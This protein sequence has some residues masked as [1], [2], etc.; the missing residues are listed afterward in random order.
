MRH[1]RITSGVA[2]IALTL[3]AAAARATDIEVLHW[4]TSGGEARALAELTK[5]LE[6]SGHR[7]RDFSVAGGGGDNAMLLLKTRVVSGYPPMAA[8]IKGP[9]IREWAEEGLLADIGDVAKAGN[10]DATL[11]TVVANAMK[12]EGRYVAAP[13]NVHRVNW[14]WI[15]P[16]VLKKSGVEPPA[17]WDAL[18][19]SADSIRKAGFVPIAHGGQPWQD[20][21][22][23]ESVALGVGG[24]DFYRR[25][26][27]SLEAATIQSPTMIKALDTFKALRKL[28][29]AGANNREW[30]AA[31]AMVINGKAAVQFMGDWAKG[32]FA[33]AG[34]QP[35]R[36][37]LCLPAP[38]TDKTYTYNIDSFAF[39]R[40]RQDDARKAQADLANALMG[41]EFQENFNLAKGSIPARTNARMDRFDDCAK[42]SAEDFRATAQSGGLVPS[43]AHRMAAPEAVQAA[44]QSAVSSFFNDPGMSSR[45]AQARLLQ[46]IAQR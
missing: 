40:Q 14:M 46:A 30:S 42:R 37:Y 39:F 23:F 43:V 21:T 16:E 24:A 33:K 17:T 10:W 35:G 45:D 19:S 4:W 38:G 7:W 15:N 25:A 31:T 9:E 27:V 29:D 44:M 28:I 6:A 3:A 18:I 12:Y 8:Q 22:L 34:K 20:F 13:V 5:K 11:P 32:E 36:D 41:A 1:A 2:A 26:F